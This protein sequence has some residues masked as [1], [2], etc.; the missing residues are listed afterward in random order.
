MPQPDPYRYDIDHPSLQ[1]GLIPAEHEPELE[2]EPVPTDAR[3]SLVAPLV[4]GASL[5][6]L[7]VWIFFGPTAE[8]PPPEL[9]RPT[10]E[11]P[12]T[13]TPPILYRALSA[14]QPW[15]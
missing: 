10:A 4:G 14:P 8:P 1:S 6:A 11:A 13:E 3:W 7:A 5:L 12:P 2:A 15:Q 9:P